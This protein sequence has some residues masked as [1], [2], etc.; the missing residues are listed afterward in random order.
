MSASWQELVADKRRRQTEAIPKDWLITPP[1]DTVLD[2]TQV[3]ESCG[4]LSD[5]DLEITNTVDVAT[6][7]HHLATAKW[8]SVEVTTAFYKR[9]IVA[10]QLVGRFSVN[11]FDVHPPLQVNCLTEIFVE[12]ALARA[13]E[14]D[15]ILKDTGKVVGPLHGLP[16]S[17]KDQV[18]I[19]GL[20]ST[21][22]K[23]V[24]AF[25]PLTTHPND[26]QGTFHGSGSMQN[27]TRFWSISSMGRE[28]CPSCARMSHKL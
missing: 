9:A 14:L 8:S 16:I 21:I 19:E 26:R 13:A 1:P 3:P 11:K 20:E 23:F 22:G 17:L 28:P 4:L 7:L 25:L 5:R 12:R 24:D 10:Q 6:I 15:A 2:V 27:G 18:C